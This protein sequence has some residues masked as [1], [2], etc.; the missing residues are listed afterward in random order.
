MDILQNIYQI[1]LHSKGVNTDSRTL[2]EGEVFIALKGDNFNGN[3]FAKAAIEKGAL[4]VICDEKQDF[5]HHKLFCVENTLAFLQLLAHHHRM[6]LNVKVIGITGSNGKT[7]TKELMRNVLS[8]TFKTQ[9]T[10]GNFN[11]HIGVPITLLQLKADTEMAIV[12]MGANHPNEIA[13]LSKI[14]H[15]EIGYITN[16]GKAHLEGFGGIEGVISA[17]SE[18]YDFLREQK[19]LALV[20]ADDPIQMEKSEGIER[21][22]FG[23]GAGNL[24]T[25]ENI[26][27]QNVALLVNSVEIRTQIKGD[28]NFKNAASAIALGLLLGVE[29][30]NIKT[31]LENYT[32]GMNRSE[33]KETEKNT[34]FL[35]AYNANPTSMELSIKNFAK[36]EHSKKLM[37]LGDMFELGKF[38]KEEHQHIAALVGKTNIETYLVGEEFASTKSEKNIRKFKTTQELYD[39]IK[40]KPI[41]NFTVLL[42]GSRG[43]R[44]ETLV[45]LL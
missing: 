17:K 37:I 40:K 38:A 35:D 22:L 13:E 34:L 5:V 33:I 44:L 36:I 39:F 24:F 7:T 6:Q 25:I 19:N 27:G 8:T 31:A 18:L 23:T 30:E 32:S 3:T 16:F 15:P 2:K 21:K 42:K 10:V 26:S 1:F 12:E 45:K 41:T 14:A 9:A 20:D 11:N 43:M 4:A 28:Y 29:I